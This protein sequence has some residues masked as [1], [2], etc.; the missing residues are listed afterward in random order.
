MYVYWMFKTDFELSYHNSF[1]TKKTKD[2]NLN[3]D[4]KNMINC[5]SKFTLNI[6]GNI[7]EIKISDIQIKKK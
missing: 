3:V 2:K 6:I 4:L 7:S 1:A 5:T